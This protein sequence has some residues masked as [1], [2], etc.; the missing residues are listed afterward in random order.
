MT[1]GV[2]V[3]LGGVVVA[4]VFSSMVADYADE[5]LQAEQDRTVAI[6]A[7]QAEYSEVRALVATV[8][9]LELAQQAAGLTEIE[10]SPFIG[11]IEQTLPG[12]VRIVEFSIVSA[13][14]LSPLIQSTDPLISRRAATIDFTAESPDL[15][16]VRLW[17]DTLREVRG[18]TDATPGA[19]TLNPSSG[20]YE[21][22]ITMGVDEQAWSPQIARAEFGGV[23][24][25]TAIVGKTGEPGDSSTEETMEHRH[26]PPG[27]FGVWRASY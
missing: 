16:N 26:L 23:T 27:L 25:R 1:V 5:R 11:E 9:F 13:T 17:L 8:E 20:L 12:D 7:Q 21:A 22:S 6:L 24:F 4:V 19:V 10:W 14:P 15:P 18:F 3:A 2:L